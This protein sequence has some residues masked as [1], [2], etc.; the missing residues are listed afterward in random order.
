MSQAEE[1]KK[2]SGRGGVN[3]L[4]VPLDRTLKARD[5]LPTLPPAGRGINRPAVEHRHTQLWTGV[6]VQ[7]SRI[8]LRCAASLWRHAVVLVLDGRAFLGCQWG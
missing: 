6:R 3:G 4:Q 7:I 2:R 1:K 5:G 8:A